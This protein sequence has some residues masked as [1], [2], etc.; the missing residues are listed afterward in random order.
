M[1]CSGIVYAAIMCLL[2]IASESRALILIVRDIVNAAGILSEVSC[3]AES[4]KRILRLIDN[5]RFSRASCALTSKFSSPFSNEEP[6]Q[7]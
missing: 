4:F 3:E 2:D 5:R 6:Y 1:S 7:S